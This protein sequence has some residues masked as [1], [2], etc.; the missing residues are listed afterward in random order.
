MEECDKKENI[1]VIVPGY[2]YVPPEMIS[3]YITNQGGY[4][5]KYIYSIFTEFYAQ[6]DIYDL[7]EDQE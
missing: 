1:E 6:D 4:T 3:L 5:P 7:D 2:D